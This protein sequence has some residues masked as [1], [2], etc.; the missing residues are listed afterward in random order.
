M[1]KEKKKNL[2]VFFNCVDNERKSQV[3]YTV[4]TKQIKIYSS[5]IDLCY[6][7][8]SS[9][10]TS[11]RNWKHRAGI[12]VHIL[13]GRRPNSQLYWSR[14]H[15]FYLTPDYVNYRRPVCMA[16]DV[17]FTLPFEIQ[18]SINAWVGFYIPV[19]LIRFFP[20]WKIISRMRGSF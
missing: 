19:S 7:I 6:F 12:W 9:L 16:L 11:E 8:V 14:L 10:A 5:K 1:A 20:V 15:T 4:N 2:I 13:F 18:D 3:F 17:V